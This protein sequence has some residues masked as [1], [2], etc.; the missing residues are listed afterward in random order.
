MLRTAAFSSIFL[1]APRGETILGAS[2][3]TTWRQRPA[4]EVGEVLDHRRPGPVEVDVAA[5]ADDDVVGDVAVAPVVDDV[6]LGQRLDVLLVADH[7][8]LGR[9]VGEEDLHG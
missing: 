3:R 2:G 1:I 8:E 5:D 6:G 9:V 7:G 4:G